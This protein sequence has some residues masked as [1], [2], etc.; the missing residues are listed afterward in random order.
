MYKLINKQDWEAA[1]CNNLSASHTYLRDQ[2][3]TPTPHPSETLIVR[4]THLGLV[5]DH[6]YHIFLYQS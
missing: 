3:G 6:E 2:L 5:I 1:A 4:P